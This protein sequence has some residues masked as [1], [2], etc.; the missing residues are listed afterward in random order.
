MSANIKSRS[1]LSRWKIFYYSV[2]LF[3]SVGVLGA[4]AQI[5]SQD[6]REAFDTVSK[7]YLGVDPQKAVSALSI[8][9]ILAWLI[10]GG[11]GFVAFMYGK[12]QSLFKPL[13]IG[14]ALM[15]YPYFTSNTLALYI[16]GSL[17]TAG[18]FIF[19]E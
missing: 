13:V 15:I 7:Q 19:R 17:L 10:F 3:L 4:Q 16:I 11:I 6:Q 1:K 9:N 14:L 8:G 12:K 5:F 2:M 18:L